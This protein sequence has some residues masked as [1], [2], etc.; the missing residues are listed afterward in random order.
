M[1]IISTRRVVR[2]GG[3][4]LIEV[5]PNQA[6]QLREHLRSHNI[7]TAVASDSTANTSWLEVRGHLAEDIEAMIGEWEVTED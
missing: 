6:E 7:Q 3:R 2:Q 5:P 1:I 4:V